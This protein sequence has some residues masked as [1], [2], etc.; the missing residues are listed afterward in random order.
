MDTRVIEVAA[1]I[2]R[3]STYVGA[4]DIVFNQ[5]LE[6]D[7]ARPRRPWCARQHEDH[8]ETQTRAGGGGQ[9]R[10][11]ALW[12]TR[13]VAPSARAAPQVHSSLRSLFPPPPRPVRC[14]V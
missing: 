2:Y 6:R 10:V 14:H 9:T 7:V 5:Y 13:V 8:I 4:A 1:D 3:L 12:R 11:V